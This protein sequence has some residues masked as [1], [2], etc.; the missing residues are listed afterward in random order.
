[1]TALKTR[2]FHHI[3]M[4]C[5]DA[6]RTL[7]FYGDLL[8]FEFVKRTVNFDDPGAYHLYFGRKGGRPGTILT[9][10]EWAHA[11]RG[12]WGVG[13][14]HHLAL[15]VATPEAQLKWKR[16]LTDAGVR[17]SGPIDRGYFTSLYLADPDGQILEIATAG[18]GYTIDEPADA[19][20]QKLITPPAARL[21][22]GR[23]QVATAALTHPEPV[24]EV[25]PDMA[26][27]GIHHITAITDDLEAAGEFYESALGL[28]LVKKTLNQDDG[29][30]KHF[31]WASYDGSS[32]APHSALTLFGWESSRDVAGPGA[33]QTHHIAFRAE[34]GEEQAAWRDHLLSLGIEVTPVRD[35][36]YFESIYFRAPDGLLLEIATDT[37]GFAVDEPE[38]SLGA[39]LKLPEW[40]EAERADIERR[41]TPLP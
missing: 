17:V 8:G 11:R 33:G 5:T 39:S 41:L 19:L 7:A 24:P 40:L 3:T 29:R 15:G 32:V 23:D 12:H 4:V 28:S 6:A 18:P 22:E 36:T 38:D 13:G 16:R 20:G 1:M 27:D 34:S 25:T 30:T 14:V 31:F 21:P 10:F 37:P 9:F 35:R 2:G 26:L